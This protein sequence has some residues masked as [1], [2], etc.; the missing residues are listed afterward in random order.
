PAPARARSVL[1]P[2][3]CGPSWR[4]T[5]EGSVP[6]VDNADGTG[7][8]RSEL[9]LEHGA[10]VLRLRQVELREEHRSPLELEQHPDA[11]PAIGRAPFETPVQA[12]VDVP[13]VCL[14]GHEIR[15]EHGTEAGAPQPRPGLPVGSPQ[16]EAP[17]EESGPRREVGVLSAED[18]QAS[19]A[20]EPPP[21]ILD[22]GEPIDDLEAHVLAPDAVTDGVVEEELVAEMAALV[23]H[24][25]PARPGSA[26]H[27]DLRSDEVI[28]IEQVG[29]IG[30]E[31]EL[32]EDRAEHAD[33][34]AVAAARLAQAPDAERAAERDQ[35]G[36]DGAAVSFCQ[37]LLRAAEDEPPVVRVEAWLALVGEQR[38]EQVVVGEEDAGQRASRIPSR[39]PGRPTDRRVAT[40]HMLRGGFERA[41][42]G[43]RR[44][45]HRE[46]ECS[47]WKATATQH[48]RP[49]A[50]NVRAIFHDSTAPGAEL[51]RTTSGC[52]LEERLLERAPR[53]RGGLAA[54]TDG[55]E[56]G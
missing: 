7:T 15:A 11:V 26:A 24:A 53:R 1:R 51:R 16:L 3:G 5:M 6:C 4:A 49:R 2:G 12:R 30:V 10:E 29:G 9:E 14:H 48:W 19:A 54:D 42:G 35:R 47:E 20:V 46:D 32:R 38:A 43:L 50:R 44:H 37:H 56:V 45:R 33:L 55:E 52:R 40:I 18:E 34:D 39:S 41:F 25:Q 17:L 28:G 23:I 31:V 27:R 8:V 36:V 21:G 13:P 22:R